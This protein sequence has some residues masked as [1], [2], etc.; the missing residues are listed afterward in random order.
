MKYRALISITCILAC[1]LSAGC[2][3]GH[4]KKD[5]EPFHEIQE[6]INSSNSI[7]SQ[8]SQTTP[9]PISVSKYN[10]I[11]RI[12]NKE[13]TVPNQA[14]VAITE[15]T[16]YSNT[17]IR[18]ILENTPSIDNY[19]T[20]LNKGQVPQLSKFISKDSIEETTSFT[21]DRVISIYT[22]PKN[23]SQ[24]RKEL[25]G[26]Y[27]VKISNINVEPFIS[28]NSKVVQQRDQEFEKQNGCTL[29]FANLNKDNLVTKG[30]IDYLGWIKD[31]DQLTKGYNQIFQDI[32]IE[33]VSPVL[34]TV[35]YKNITLA[36]DVHPDD[37]RKILKKHCKQTYTSDDPANMVM[38][39]MV[40]SSQ[41]LITKVAYYTVNL[42][43][44]MIQ[45]SLK[46]YDVKNEKNKMGDRL[47]I[48][49]ASLDDTTRLAEVQADDSMNYKITDVEKRREAKKIEKLSD[50]IQTI[51]N[52]TRITWK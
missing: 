20:S 21:F 37:L 24:K 38:N 28:Y 43:G 48:I 14:T 3:N 39:N 35:Y 13:E 34:M 51:Q 19:L 12:E 10:V 4:Q 16:Q 41:A 9:D 36:T 15:T 6:E 11:E 27:Q 18:S 26:K 17:A 8:P 52:N 1:L 47:A 22:P 45:R 29:T 31:K 50:A 30:T 40:C 49:Q 32:S 33:S 2:N 46:Y 44:C 25:S 7:E 5:N 23:E 42:Q